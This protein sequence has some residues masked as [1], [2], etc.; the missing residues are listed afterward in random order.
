MTII[1][2]KMDLNV[3]IYNPDGTIATLMDGTP[4]ISIEGPPGIRWPWSTCI[5]LG[6]GYFLT[7]SHNFNHWERSE[8]AKQ[9][10]DESKLPSYDRHFVTKEVYI[11]SAKAKDTWKDIRN[12]NPYEAFKSTYLPDGQSQKYPINDLAVFKIDYK[13]SNAN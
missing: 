3:D 13:I 11:G 5:A 7:A 12:W 4:A 9:E 1:S 2:Q 10:K 8:R 6:N